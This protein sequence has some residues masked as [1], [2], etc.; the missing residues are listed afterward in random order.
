M[1][2]SPAQASSAFESKAWL[3]YYPEWTKPNLDYGTETLL[4]SYRETMEEFGERPATWFFGHQMTYRELDTHVRAAAAGLKAFGIRPGDRVAVALPNCPQHVAVFYAILKLGATVVEH[5]PLYTAAELEPLFQDHAARVAVVWDKASP[6]FEE[7]RDTTPLETIVTVNMIEAMPRPKQL[8]LRLPLPIIKDKRAE[9]SVPAPNTVPWS[10]LTGRAIGGQG[11]K[12]QDAKVNRDDTALILYT[13]GT[14]GRPKGAE[15]TH[16]NLYCNMKMAEAW[17]PEI[18]KKPERMLAALPLFHVYGLTLIAALGVHIGGELVLT[19]APKIPLL[20]DIMKKRRPTWM[21]GVPTIYSKVMEA[22]K[23]Q[24]IDLHGIENSLSGAAAL[25]ADIVEEWETLTGG[26]LVEG[27]GLTETSPIVAAN[28]LNKNR[29]PGYIGIP[30]PDTEVRIGNP[31]NLSETQPDGT[32]GELLVRGP[33]VFKGYFN[34][35]E[36]TE[37]SFHDGWYR[38]GDMAIMEPDGFIKIVS[39]IKEMIITGG[40]NVYPAE[41]E[42]VIRQHPDVTNVAIVGRPRA[43]GSEDVVACIVLEDGAVLDP[44]G[45][46]DYC[47]ERLTRYKV[48]RTFYHFEQLASDQLGKVRRREVQKDLLKLLG[49]EAP[50]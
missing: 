35:P 40:F 46:K 11:Q 41:V 5:N 37:Q 9:L 17:V 13:S 33:Q 19:P 16:S 32:A 27:Y 29:R 10:T 30:F 26:L 36:A 31:D 7:L 2:E 44:E 12:L 21:P 28:P 24:N 25:P 4:D 42:D 49:E 34:M 3:Q 48:P 18:G 39:R 47:R 23:E 45:L 15:L 20:L 14:T 1:S 43:D 50:A 8:L 22:A 6:V 38:T